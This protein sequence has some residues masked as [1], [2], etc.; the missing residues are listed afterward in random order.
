MI[1]T[2]DI[3]FTTDVFVD[4]SKAFDTC[5][6]D[7]LTRFLLAQQFNENLFADDAKTFF[8]AGYI[9]KQIVNSKS[10]NL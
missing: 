1:A 5:H 9:Y 2:D 3:D 7:A 6:S 10:L 8:C 4:H